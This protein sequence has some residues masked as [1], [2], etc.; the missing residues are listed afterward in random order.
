MRF[1]KRLAPLGVVLVAALLILYAPDVA[2]ERYGDLGSYFRTE[3]ERQGFDGWVVVAF[4][5]GKPDFVEAFGTDGGGK[6]LR[7]DQ[8]MPIGPLAESFTGLLARSLEAEGRFV[9]DRDLADYLEELSVEAWLPPPDPLPPVDPAGAG[10]EAPAVSPQALVPQP[11]TARY[12]LA[13]RSGYSALD[14]RPSARDSNLVATFNGLRRRSPPGLAHHE[15]P[16]GY[17][18]VSQAL[19]RVSGK[20]WSGLLRARVLRPLGMTQVIVPG[21]AGG[22]ALSEVPRGS[23][24]FF[25]IG[26]PRE[27]A[28]MEAG[29]A[30]GHLAIS[31]RDLRA[32]LAWLAAP[33]GFRAT[34]LPARSLPGL[35]EPLFPGGDFGYGWEIREREG[36]REL[37]RRGSVEGFQAA[38]ALWPE[39]QAGM[40]ILAPRTGLLSPRL[41]MPALLEGGRALMLEGE[42]PRGFPFGRLWTLFGIA[43]FVQVA[44]LVLQTGRA[45]SWA[46]HARSRA[47]ARGSRFLHVWARLRTWIGIGVRVGLALAAPPLVALL[48]DAPMDWGRA[49]SF[50]PGL[51][52][53]L[54]GVLGFG[55]LRNL[56]RLAWLRGLH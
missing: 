38:A 26:L 49:F 33:R 53:W 50:E 29:A 12:L 24:S 27:G 34:I 31:G 47:E 54:A 4:A 16:E 8:P 18:L 1:L 52:A 46:R 22:P 39:R 11:L 19:E 51:A 30:T 42:A 3:L 20:P 25:G 43:A 35:V 40:A 55:V 56:A 17:L 32:W 44:V 23:A 10:A 13:M 14:L 15:F 48:L 6:P 7:T 21:E 5:R 28:V 41:V 37:L 9:L 36:G 45:L 2:P